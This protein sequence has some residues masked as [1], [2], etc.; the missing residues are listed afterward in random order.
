MRIDQSF[1]GL[2]GGLPKNRRS[3]DDSGPGRVAEPGEVTTGVQGQAPLIAHVIHRL[4]VGGLENGLVN[5]INHVPAGRFR[6]AVVCLTDYT[7]FRERFEREIPVYALHKRE[8]KDPGLYA[9]LWRLLRDLKPDI[10][11][12]R[13]LAA[14][15][16]QLCARLA[17]V[18][19]RV[20]GEHGRDVHDLDGTRLRY[21]WLR[22]GFRPLVDRY[23]AL[24]Q[25]LQSY[26]A[27]EIAVPAHKIVQ[28]YNGVD[29]QRF[30]PAGA[31]DTSVLPAGF[32]LPGS[33]VIGSVG[34]M[35]EVKD[36]MTLVEAFV[37]LTQRLGQ[38]A[39]RVRLV[40]VGDGPLHG[41]AQARLRNAGL[42]TRAW[43]PGSREDVPALLRAM[44]V[45]V[46]PSLA[47]GISN[48]VLEAMASGLP[49]VATAVGGNAELIVDGECG[50]IVPR[51]DPV[52]MAGSLLGYVGD[53]GMRERH[54]RAARSR[55]EQQFTLDAMVQRYV[56]L[57]E[58]LLGEKKRSPDG[59]QR[60]PG[61]L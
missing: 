35:Q 51:D 12:T 43:L 33:V 48:T 16:G 42:E 1:P 18:S 41:A 31:R 6:H 52:A 56:Q 19:C 3:R 34:R 15:E 50:A 57:Y 23:V 22:K 10:V 13:N 37:H 58:E 54:G 24:S 28:I 21:R 46:L 25:E 44:D 55:A 53:E 60:N 29:G 8:G 20:H 40:M 36:P 26:L 47:E 61:K 14:L 17:G 30:C 45:F 32:A 38:G 39:E 49:V 27:R 7:D 9:R 11:H 4:D 59:A 2:R 5:L